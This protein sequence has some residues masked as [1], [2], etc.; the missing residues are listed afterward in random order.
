M[1]KAIILYILVIILFTSFTTIFIY[2]KI[3]KSTPS[4]QIQIGYMI[5]NNMDQIEFKK[6]ITDVKDQNAV[7]YIE[8]IF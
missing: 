7:D 4:R 8:G 1:K 6:I 3:Q 2:K 5:S